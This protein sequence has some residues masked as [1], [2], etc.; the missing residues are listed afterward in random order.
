M[1][2]LF[3]GIA[4]IREIELVV[5]YCKVWPPFLRENDVIV[6]NAIALRIYV[7]F[8]LHRRPDNR[9]SENSRQELVPSAYGQFS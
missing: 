9:L 5:V 3:P 6:T 1:C 7:E 8:S 2:K 4:L